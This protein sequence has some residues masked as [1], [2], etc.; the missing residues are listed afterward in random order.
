M[1]HQLPNYIR[2]HRKR[3]A[4]TQD[5]LAGLL[6]LTS[7]GTISQY[8]GTEKR[9]IVEILIGAK[10]IFNV[11]CHEM[12]PRVYEEVERDLVVRAKE[13]LAKLDA[14][15]DPVTFTKRAF[16]GDLIHRI[17]KQPPSL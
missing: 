3:W 12:F 2:A 15:A 9:P 16:L 14:G 13:L 6:G 5:E 7:Q 4:L 1:N 10:T 11:P 8:E 17:E